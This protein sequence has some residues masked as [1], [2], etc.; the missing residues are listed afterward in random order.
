MAI[1]VL[2]APG[3]FQFTRNPVLISLV[4]DKYLDTAGSAAVLTISFTVP[5]L[6]T[7]V[8]FR[9]SC[10]EGSFDMISMDAPITEDGDH[11]TT[12][13]ALSFEQW[14]ESFGQQINNNFFIGENYTVTWDTALKKVVLTA[15]EKGSN[16]ALVVT[17]LPGSASSVNTGGTDEVKNE[18]FSILVDVIHMMTKAVYRTEAVFT[19]AWIGPTS[20][21]FQ[22]RI[23][24]ILDGLVQPVRPDGGI[25]DPVLSDWSFVTGYYLRFFEYYGQPPTA[26][27]Y[28]QL[29]NSGDGYSAVAG[30]LNKYHYPDISAFLQEYEP[31]VQFLTW[32]PRS[33]HVFANQPEWLSFYHQHWDGWDTDGFVRIVVTYT[34]G[35]TLTNSVLLQFDNDVG[36]NSLVYFPAGYFQ[37]IEGIADPLKTVEKW[38]VQAYGFLAD[39]TLTAITELFTYYLE[40]DTLPVHT[41]FILFQN[42]FMCYDT[43]ACTGERSQGFDVTGEILEKYL[44]ANYSNSDGEFASSQ[45]EAFERYVFNTGLLEKAEMLTYLQELLHTSDLL[46]VWQPDPE[47]WTTQLKPLVMIR[48][49]VRVYQDM[50]TKDRYYLEFECRDAYRYQGH[51]QIVA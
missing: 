12:Q 28:Y 35:S 10:E 24:N 45:A 47:D 11:F 39:E 9:A 2:Q 25:I 14:I 3:N 50:Q 41:R 15:K 8:H 51:G 22:A 43:I 17:S 32:Q 49:S 42:S 4:S 48:K 44:A 6:L 29:D 30:G 37:I 23:E 33:K 1:T 5:C 19:S 7:G 16:W 26:K 38:T 40:G 20:A 36:K 46:E 21:V 27:H 18:N 31:P 13:G 34:D